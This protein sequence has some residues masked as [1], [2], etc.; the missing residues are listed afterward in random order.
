M[1][2][3]VQMVKSD[4]VGMM[5][6]GWQLDRGYCW[7][8]SGGGTSNLTWRV[9]CEPEGGLKPEDAAV[10]CRQL[11]HCNGSSTMMLTLEQPH[12]LVCSK[13]CF[14]RSNCFS[15]TMSYEHL[16]QPSNLDIT[17]LLQDLRGTSVSLD[18]NSSDARLKNSTAQISW[19]ILLLSWTT[20]L[21]SW[22]TGSP[23]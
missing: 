20:P 21:F 7:W 12:V 17:L 15:N 23:D 5:R 13:K 10:V 14:A 4:Q 16:W 2:P 22:T 1:Q 8:Q 3:N 18:I 9:M 19:A 11:S 6:W